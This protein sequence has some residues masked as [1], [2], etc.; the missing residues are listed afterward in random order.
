MDH[1]AVVA[2]LGLHGLDGLR[3]PRRPRR[4]KREDPSRRPEDD[5]AVRRCGG[6]AELIPTRGP[7]LAGLAVEEQL[8]RAVVERHEVPRG[9]D[10]HGDLPVIGDHP[11]D[12]LRRQRRR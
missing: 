5:P 2:Q 6:R 4:R 9:V 1:R 7:G 10:A 12:L 3:A 8:V 11:G